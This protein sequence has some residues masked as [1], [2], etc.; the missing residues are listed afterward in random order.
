M[1]N[2]G[3]TRIDVN[4]VTLNLSNAALFSQVHLNDMSLAPSGH[5][6]TFHLPAPVHLRPN[7]EASFELSVLVAGAAGASSVSGGPV[8]AAFVPALGYAQGI[9]GGRGS[10]LLTLAAGLML[11]GMCLR[12]DDRRIRS[13]L[14][15]G[16]VLISIAGLAG[17]DRCAE[18]A[19]VVTQTST[20]TVQAIAA[21]S[22]KVTVPVQG[23][24]LTLGTITVTS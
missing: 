21:T 19:R 4:S 3:S 6:L 8:P 11:L 24:K 16:V 1:R 20:Q 5:T 22:G 2:I 9:A 23:L 13:A 18:C 15:A 7:G 10:D 12:L 17:C 14:V